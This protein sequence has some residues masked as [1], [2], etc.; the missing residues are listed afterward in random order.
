MRSVALARRLGFASVART[1]TTLTFL[2]TRPFGAVDRH[3][4]ASP[5]AHNNNCQL[6]SPP[7]FS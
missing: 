4:V 3:V 6:T 1:G 7:P 5:T 2:K